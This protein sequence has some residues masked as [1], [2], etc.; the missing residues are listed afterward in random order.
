MSKQSKHIQEQVLIAKAIAAIK[1]QLRD[2]DA[3]KKRYIAAAVVARENGI[4]SQYNLAK[5]AIRIVIAQKAVVEQMLMTL[6]LSAQLKDVSEMTKTFADG[7]KSLSRSASR[8]A[9]KLKF[10][11]VSGQV[12]Q[13][14]QSVKATQDSADIFLDITQSGFARYADGTGIA[15]DDIDALID[16]EIALGGG[17]DAEIAELEKIINSG[18]VGG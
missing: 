4:A 5:N 15:A 16:G 2:L 7:M 13:A 3:S 1:K 17:L 10:D 6:Q 9:S 14:V 12:A 8:T 18:K 11:K